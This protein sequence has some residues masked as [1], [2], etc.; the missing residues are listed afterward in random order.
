MSESIPHRRVVIVDDH[1]IMR[2][3]IKLLLENETD[4]KVC[5]EAE[6]ASDAIRVIESTKPD[7]VIVDLTLSQG[8]GL[9]LIKDLSQRFTDI[10]S[11]A[12]SMHDE[13]LFAERV[14]KAG[15][16]GYVMKQEGGEKLLVAVRRA[17][18]GQIY[19]SES[20]AAR[21]LQ[22][23]SQTASKSKSGR[24]HLEMLT[25]REFEVFQWTGQGMSP[26]EIAESLNLS[27][28]TVEAHRTNIRRKL[29]IKDATALVRYA[30]RWVETQ[31][32]D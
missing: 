19:V 25:D 13:N 10:V 21:L 16:K 3:G 2:Q 18:S 8:S 24:S 5:G 23:L 22:N 32:M 20:V 9:E 26:R 31:K 1:P 7:L 15:A 12:L 6:T 30:V 4:L 28:K 14:I 11:L 27:I 17:L 29:D